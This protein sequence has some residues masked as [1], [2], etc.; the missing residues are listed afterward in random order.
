MTLTAVATAATSPTASRG[1][2]PLRVS[3]P[4]GSFNLSGGI[5]VLATLANGMAARGWSVKL[6]VPAFAA[7]SPFPL[8]ARVEVVVLSGG[9]AWL[10][11]ALRQ[12]IHYLRLAVTSARAVDLCLAN[13]F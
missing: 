11:L 5:K 3:I 10:P 8:D 4:L 9:P 6:L 12:V 1:A 13:Y 7:S 2:R